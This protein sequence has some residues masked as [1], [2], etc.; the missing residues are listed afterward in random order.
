MKFREEIIGDC[1]LILGDCLEIMPGLGKFDAVVTDPPFGLAFQSNYR[2]IKHNKIAND[3]TKDLLRFACEITISHSRYVFCRWDNIFDIPK[4]KSL[5]TWIK[6]NWTMGDLKHEHGR[7]TEVCAFYPG[8]NHYFPN[9]RPQDVIRAPQTGNDNHP[10]EKPVGLMGAVVGWT[11]GCILDPFMG[12]GTTGVACA[13][14]GR[15]FTGIE[16]DEAYFDIACKRIEDAYKQP[17]MFVEPP[18]PAKQEALI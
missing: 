6:N 1:R 13:K 11:V 17:D 3:N 10:T 5:I 15:K 14:L 8:S 9:G 18:K 16:L 12:S 7:Q 4:P 2:H